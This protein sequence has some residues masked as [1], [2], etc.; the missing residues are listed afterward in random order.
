MGY[1][2]FF[3]WLLF[4]IFMFYISDNIKPKDKNLQNVEQ[5]KMSIVNYQRHSY[6]V[7]SINCGGGICH[8][9]DCECQ[10][11]ERD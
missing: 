5:G 4:A 10:K 7:W 1:I 3:I 9:P 6:I 2:I 8:N 11:L